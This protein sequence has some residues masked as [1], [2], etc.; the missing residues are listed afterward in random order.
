VDRVSMNRRD[1]LALGLSAAIPGVLKSGAACAAVSIEP[2]LRTL[3]RFIEGYCAAM[4][5]PGLTLGLANAQGTLYGQLRVVQRRRQLWIG[6]TDPLVPIGDHLFRV[7]ARPS[8]P[9]VA[10]FSDLKDGA[11]EFLWFDGGAFRRIGAA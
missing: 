4:N 6:G 11:P 10:E 7:G 8:S 3:D 9:E 2:A 1:L 5:A